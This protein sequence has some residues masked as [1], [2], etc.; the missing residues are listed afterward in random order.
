MAQAKSGDTVQVHY[1]GRLNDGTIFDSSEGRDPLEF[2]LGSGM[3]IAGF[4]AGITGMSVGEKKTVN[5]PV[6][7]AYGPINE[8][9]I[10]DV[11]RTEIPADIPLEVGMQLN[12]H[13]DGNGQVIP[14]T[15]TEL[16]EDRVTLDANHILAGK[17]LI[18]DLELVGVG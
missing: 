3:V 11:E 13:V 14:V 7:E 2:Q 1:T 18:F 10:T 9:M 16:T 6:E 5:I 12:M 8:E 17:D 15:V 4:D